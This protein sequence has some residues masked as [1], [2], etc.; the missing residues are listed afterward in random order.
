MVTRK[1][2]ICSLL[3][4]TVL[5]AG[6]VPDNG[7]LQKYTVAVENAG[8]NILIIFYSWSGNTRNIAKLAQKKTGGDLLE[9]ELVKHYSSNYNA[10]V[11]EFK[12][13][14]DSESKRELKT[15]LPDLAQYDTIFLGFPI[16]GGSIPTPISTMLKQNNFSGKTIVPFCSHGG[17][18]IGRSVADIQKLVPGSSVLEGLSVYYSGRGSLEWDM[19]GW[20]RKN[21]FGK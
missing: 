2:L 20:L 15:R 16:W 3:V 11:D 13:E 7:L 18:G 12:R 21:G 10:C 19:D 5:L 8:G 14:R 1:S 9:L 4:T 17:G 6:A